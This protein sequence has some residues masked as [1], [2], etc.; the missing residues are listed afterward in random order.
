MATK[1]S[2]DNSKWLNASVA[3]T[4]IM[5]CFILIRFFKQIG[6]W[7]ELESKLGSYGL[8]TQAVAVILSIG[9]FVYILKNEKTSSFLKESFS[10]IVKVI[11]PDRN[12]TLSMTWKVMILVTICGFILGLF[13]YF[14]TW[15]LSLL[16]GWV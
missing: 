8:I 1:L 3:I 9:S 11:F 10:E 13:D 14:A 5:L 4:C 12:E 6:E 16:P 7:F 2:K 15:G